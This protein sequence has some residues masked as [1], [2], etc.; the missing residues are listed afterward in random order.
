MNP[1][2]HP[3]YQYPAYEYPADYVPPGQQQPVEAFSPPAP[4]RKNNKAFLIAASVFLVLTIIVGG[5]I[6]V[7]L[8]QDKTPT[9][10]VEQ[11]ISDWRTK[12]GPDFM[13]VANTMDL[14]AKS[15]RNED[16]SGVAAACVIL[17]HDLKVAR[18]N[19]PTPDAK[20]TAET[21]AALDDF[22]NAAITCQN[23]DTAADVNM[24]V[25]YMDSGTSHI[26]IATK[27]MDDAEAKLKGGS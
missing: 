6:A 1:D 21:A 17:E 4:P 8:L 14:I 23:M 10:S 2:E 13:K 3:T 12:A 16:I 22:N 25:Q 24:V 15:A 27:I 18:G 11:Q 7:Y 19:L 26:W 20:L 5:G 9:V